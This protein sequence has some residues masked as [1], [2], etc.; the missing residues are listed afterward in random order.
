MQLTCLWQFDTILLTWLIRHIYQNLSFLSKLPFCVSYP[1]RDLADT[2]KGS[3][4]LSL[5]WFLRRLLRLPLLS[6]V[7]PF[8]RN[9]FSLFLLV[10]EDRQTELATKVYVGVVL[11]WNR[12]HVPGLKNLPA[13]RIAKGR[14]NSWKILWGWQGKGWSK[15]RG[16]EEE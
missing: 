16:K 9:L 13:N 1:I 11:C 15:Q 6:F 2:A 7:S 4:R 3:L 10:S 12:D 8:I 5:R 14:N